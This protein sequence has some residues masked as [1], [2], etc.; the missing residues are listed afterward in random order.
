MM[1]RLYVA[2]H[3]MFFHT[4]IKK[5]KSALMFACVAAVVLLNVVHFSIATRG[6]ATLVSIPEVQGGPTCCLFDSPF[7]ATHSTNV[8]GYTSNSKSFV[9][10]I[11][12]IS[13][14][15]SILNPPKA[16]ELGL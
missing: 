3:V 2:K 1:R 8:V 5:A 11:G 14:F 13:D 9:W 4:R 16:D 7:S 6:W 10:S 15:N 12:N